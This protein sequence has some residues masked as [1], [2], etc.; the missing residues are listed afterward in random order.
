MPECRVALRNYDVYLTHCPGLSNPH[1]EPLEFDDTDGNS[2]MIPLHVLRANN[3]FS[4][5]A[6][7]ADGGCCATSGPY[8]LQTSSHPE[9]ILNKISYHEMHKQ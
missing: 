6:F 2:I 1:S 5:K 3:L 7:D 4:V 9:G 8:Y